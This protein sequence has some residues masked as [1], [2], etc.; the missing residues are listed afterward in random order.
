[1][2]TAELKNYLHKLTVETDE[3]SILQ[4][5]VEYFELLKRKHEGDWWNSISNEEQR[6]IELGLDD[7]E[8]GNYVSHKEVMQGAQDII[9]RYGK[10][11]D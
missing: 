3:D 8:N 1:M 6:S 5:V 4:M 10:S 7:L 11:N 9:D 2:S